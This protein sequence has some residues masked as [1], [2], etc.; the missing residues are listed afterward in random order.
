MKVTRAK[1]AKNTKSNVP[2][3]QRVKEYAVAGLL[4]LA[5]VW[6]LYLNFNIA[7]KEEIARNAAESTQKQLAS[8]QNRQQLLQGNITELSTERG[9]EATMRETFGVA[10]PGEGV[11]IVVP[12]KVATTT[13]PQTFTQKWFGWVPFWHGG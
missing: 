1:S 13:P 8:L 2:P 11:I 12:P 3:E 9:Q 4:A 6:L 7:R 10:K 5:L